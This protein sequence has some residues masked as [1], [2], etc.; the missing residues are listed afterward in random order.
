MS[1]GRFQRSLAMTCRIRGPW[2]GALL[3]ACA[4]TVLGNAS[5]VFAR[6]GG[7]RTF[8]LYL[9]NYFEPGDAAILANFDALGLNADIPVSVLDEIR[10]YHPSI[11]LLAFI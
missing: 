4:L 3:L 5:T 2:A 6:A 10:G 7:P 11:K 1:G 8:C 9:S